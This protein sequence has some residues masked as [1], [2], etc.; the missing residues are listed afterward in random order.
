VYSALR[1]GDGRV[2]YRT[3]RT[4]TDQRRR[5]RALIATLAPPPPPTDLHEFAVAVD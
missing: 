4:H 5:E 1:S 2:Q 3:Y